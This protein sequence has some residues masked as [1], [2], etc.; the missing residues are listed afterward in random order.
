MIVFARIA[1]AAAVCLSLSTTVTAQ[2]SKT[3]GAPEA[4]QAGAASAALPA[5]RG[6][7]LSPRFA[8]AKGK[9]AQAKSWRVVRVYT[10]DR[11]DLVDLVS[12]QGG[13]EIKVTVPLKPSQAE[14]A[15]LAP[16]DVLTQAAVRQSNM[17]NLALSKGATPVATVGLDVA[18]LAGG[19]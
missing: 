14:T 17:T 15:R 9:L 11:I 18:G 3:G 7:G 8:D 1:L 10:E 4:A 2:V 16:G 13:K 6:K 19:R 12:T 5:L